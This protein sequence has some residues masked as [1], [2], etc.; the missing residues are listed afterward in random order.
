MAGLIP[1][2]GEP[3][4]SIR[5]L[6]E[7]GVHFGHQTNRW[8]PK[9]RS[10]IYGARNGI[11]IIDL[12]KTAKLFRQAYEAVVEAV[13]RG[14]HV[15]FVGTKRQAVDI[16]VEEAQRCGMFYVVNR[17]L[18]GTLTN[19]RTIRQALDRLKLL[20]RMAEDGTYQSLPKKET[21]QLDKERARLEKYIGG[22]KNMNA[23]PSVMFVVDPKQEEIAVFEGRR[24][25]IPIIAITDTNCDPDLI[26]YVIPGNDDAIRAIKLIT[27]RIADACI[28]GQ[29]RRKDFLTA[30]AKRAEKAE[31][32]RPS[33]PDDRPAQGAAPMPAVDFVPRRS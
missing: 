9:M 6:L 17:W 12:G 10:F 3:P 24:L 11:H 27:G 30:P 19:F 22:I 13:A 23:L 5:D 26:D 31:P 29:Q 16:V 21:L 14:G 8:N 1:Q 32:G 15:L 33:R 25:E 2:P 20:E 18:G 7:A 4:L 28:E